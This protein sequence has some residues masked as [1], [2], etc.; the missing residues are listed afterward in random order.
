MRGRLPA[1]LLPADGYAALEVPLQ[2]GGRE[3]GSG[4]GNR[5][6]SEWEAELLL[7]QKAKAWEAARDWHSLASS[8]PCDLGIGRAN[9]ELTTLNAPPTKRLRADG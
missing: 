1:G 7:D 8:T 6:L 4:N 5:Q 3:V 9:A 2:T